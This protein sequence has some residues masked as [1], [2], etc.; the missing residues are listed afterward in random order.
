MSSFKSVLTHFQQ[1]SAVSHEV[2]KQNSE[3]TLSLFFSFSLNF[4]KMSYSSTP[5]INAS[6][7]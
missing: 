4:L 6:A 1:H 5:I 7:V 3:F 2:E